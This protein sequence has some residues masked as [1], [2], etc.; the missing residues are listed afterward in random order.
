MADPGMDTWRA[1]REALIDFY[2][3]HSCPCR[4]PRLRAVVARDTSRYDAHL[5]LGLQKTRARLTRWSRL[6]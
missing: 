4:F 3:H 1:A 2:L 5:E 6:S